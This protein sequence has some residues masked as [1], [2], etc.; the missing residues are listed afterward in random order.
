[1]SRR[2]N[3]ELDHCSFVK[4]V[5]ML[6]VVLYHSCVFWTGNW[7]VETPVYPSRFLEVLAEYLNSFHIY[8]FTL[9]SGYLFSYLK[10]E[11]GKYERFLPF[12]VNKAKRLL[13]PYV[14]VAAV[15]VIPVSVFFSG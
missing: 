11:K 5:L 2:A 13:V 4:T 14:F 15:W 1:M 6:F 9:V 8:A 10:L 12:T 3:A 7:F